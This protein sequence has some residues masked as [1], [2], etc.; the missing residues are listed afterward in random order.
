MA[1]NVFPGS[2]E[3]QWFIAGRWEQYTGERRANQLRLAAIGIFYIVQLL[4]FYLFS[5]ASPSELPFH[6]KATAIAVAWTMMAVGVTLCLRLRMFP[7]ALPYLS[8]GIDIVLL[9]GLA[10]LANGPSSPLVLGYFVIICL[11]ALRF[12][13]ALVWFGTVGSMIGYW[14]LVGIVDK[15]WFDAQHAVPPKTQLLTLVSLAMS[16]LIIGQVVRRAK[17]LAGEYARRSNAARG[18]V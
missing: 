10:T 15:T 16:G 3:R 5:A 9:T 7:T 14:L 11:A 17:S 2:D 18:A 13:L 6:Q 8:T 1:T 12:S 4:H